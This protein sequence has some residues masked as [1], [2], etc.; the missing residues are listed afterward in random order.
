M[1]DLPAAKRIKLDVSAE[2]SP[3]GSPTATTVTNE[4]ANNGGAVPIPG[5]VD[6]GIYAYVNDSVPAYT[7]TIK[8]RTEDFLVHEVDLA[9]NIVH[10]KSRVVPEVVNAESK[11]E[12]AEPGEPLE[13]FYTKLAELESPDFVEQFKAMV[14]TKNEAGIELVTKSIADKADR[15]VLHKGIKQ[16]FSDFLATDSKLGADGACIVFRTARE[17]DGQPRVSKKGKQP[18]GKRAGEPNWNE[19]GNYCE[20][21]LYKENKDSMEAVALIAKMI[22]TQTKTFTFAGTKDKRAITVQRVSAYRTTMNALAGLNRILRGIQIGDFE[23]KKKRLEL[24][25]LS[26]NHFVI[27]LRDVQAPSE[28]VIHT[29]LESLRDNGFINYYGMQRF[30]SRSILTHTVG[31]EMLNGRFDQA[32]DLVMRP[33]DE[34]RTD[35]NDARKHW[36]EHKDPKKALEIFPRQCHAERAILQYFVKTGRTNDYQ[37][38]MMAIARN[39]RLMYVHAYQSYVWNTVASERVKLYPL[40]PVIGDLVDVSNTSDSQADSDDV[41]MTDDAEK[42]EKGEKS[43]INASI[44]LIESE[45]QA[46]MYTMDQVVLPLPGYAVR[47]PKH[48]VGEVYGKVMARDGLDPNDMERKQKS[49]HLKGSYRKVIAKP[50]SVDWKLFRYNDAHIP[51]SQTDLDREKDKPAP[52]SIP[53]GKHLAIVLELTL[54]QSQYATMALREAMKMSTAQAMHM[55]RANRSDKGRVVKAEGKV[56]EKEGDG[57]DRKRKAE[58]EAGG[59]G[60][61]DGQ[62]EKKVKMDFGE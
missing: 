17:G 7:G 34:E 6:V 53:D 57:G 41:E 15:T 29:S 16:H 58:N 46:K 4:A 36:Q 25:S 27:T 8:H 31:I 61:E 35:F 11:S 28:E 1:A 48:R 43:D 59:D 62:S 56:E 60:V 52:E 26:G 12:Q 30:G 20:F 51:L 49:A 37:G 33:K 2:E 3:A 9:G 19:V 21:T 18:R 38:A 13:T 5:E 42:G 24:G 55:E 40:H 50:T 54:K 23:Y 32:V 22:K 14:E 45:E 10:L 47:Y 44:V 39:M